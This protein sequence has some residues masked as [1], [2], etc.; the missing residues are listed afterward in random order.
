MSLSGSR[1]ITHSSWYE[2]SLLAVDGGEGAPPLSS[3][4]M[5]A[6]VGCGA[7]LIINGLTSL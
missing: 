3:F 2:S 5:V 4:D 6:S 7:E 1:Q